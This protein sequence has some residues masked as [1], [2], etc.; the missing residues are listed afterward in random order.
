MITKTKLILYVS[1]FIIL[2][3][4]MSYKSYYEG[5]GSDLTIYDYPNAKSSYNGDIPF[6][7]YSLGSTVM[8]KPTDT[9][10]AYNNDIVTN[11]TYVSKNNKDDIQLIQTFNNIVGSNSDPVGSYRTPPNYNRVN[12]SKEEE[13]FVIDYVMNEINSRMPYKFQPLDV[14]SVTKSIS[15][16]KD[17]N[18]IVRYVVNLFIIEDRANK[19]NT[20]TKNI[21][22][23]VYRYTNKMLVAFMKLQGKE[24]ETGSKEVLPGYRK[25][26]Y[27]RIMNKLHLLNPFRTSDDRVLFPEE[28]IQ[29]LVAQQKNLYDNPQYACFN[30]NKTNL[31]SEADCKTNNGIWDTPV[32][33]DT[34]CPYYLANKN[35]N[36]QRGGVTGGNRC[37]MPQGVKAIGYRFQAI[38]SKP[39]CYNCRLGSDGKPGSIGPC[40]EEQ[41]NRALYPDLLSPDYAFNGDSID[42]GHM[43]FQLA[44]KGLHWQ[45]NPSNQSER[46]NV[47]LPEEI[48]DRDQKDPVF[49][50]ITGL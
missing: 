40:C 48:A 28:T 29:Q 13:K 21:T 43:K 8:G 37:D 12:A 47:S 22:F 27:F 44:A 38:D 24:E 32:K 9:V 5:F 7:L 36:N 14:Q 45:P 34:E 23:I 20:Y 26:N 50:K 49:K 1:L 30:T 41:K 35:Y 4:L 46:N 42:R 3:V 10:V 2:I 17:K 39:L 6:E 16:D 19:V 15:Q 11:N 25:D 18:P 31:T 33:A